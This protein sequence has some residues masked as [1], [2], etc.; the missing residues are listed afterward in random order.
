M[1]KQNES[2]IEQCNNKRSKIYYRLNQLEDI[3][4]LSPRMLKY[5]MK[6]IKV[7]YSNVPTLL[8]RKGKSWKIH[9]SIINEFMPIRKR[10]VYTES[11]YLWR[12]YTTWNP[13][14]NYPAD[15]HLQLIREVKDKLPNSLIKYAVE[16]DRREVNHTHFMTD[17]N[18]AD[19][20]KA[21]ELVMKKYFD[22]SEVITKIST[23]NNKYSS[24][25]YTNKAPLISGII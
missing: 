16:T 13:K 6:K 20:K 12:T 3:T 21:V 11:S 7:K 10:K 24:V 19:T 23:I 4:G 1:K 2:L 18:E 15:Y 25:S 8:N 5:K 9:I 17:A 22:K 14:F